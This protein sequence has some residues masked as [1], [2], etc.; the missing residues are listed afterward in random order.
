MFVL[1]VI[2][3]SAFH[4]VPQ[5]VLHDFKTR[6]TCE[7]AS[8]VLTAQLDDTMGDTSRDVVIKCVAK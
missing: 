2:V 8:K 7:A 4:P 3:V 6:E 5:I 1:M